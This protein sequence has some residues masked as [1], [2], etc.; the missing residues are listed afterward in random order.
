MICR[1]TL[2]SPASRHCSQCHHFIEAG[3]GEPVPLSRWIGINLIM[4][5]LLIV[6]LNK[7]R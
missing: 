4:S 3:L 6:T 1:L 2:P 5:E 7:S